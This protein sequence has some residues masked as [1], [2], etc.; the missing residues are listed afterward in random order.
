MRLSGE[1]REV[2]LVGQAHIEVPRLRVVSVDVVIQH[3]QSLLLDFTLLEVVHVD[4]D[5]I[6]LGQNTMSAMRS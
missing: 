2:K 3:E 4:V 6:Y 5:S 1:R